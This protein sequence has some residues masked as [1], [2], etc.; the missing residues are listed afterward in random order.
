MKHKKMNVHLK[1]MAD[2][3]LPETADSQENILHEIKQVNKDE[4][5]RSRDGSLGCTMI[6]V[7]RNKTFI[8]NPTDNTPQLTRHFQTHSSSQG[9]ET[10]QSLTLMVNTE[11]LKNFLHSFLAHVST[12]HA[13][14]LRVRGTLLPSILKA[15]A[16]ISYVCMHLVYSLIEGCG[17]FMNNPYR[18]SPV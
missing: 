1:D 17:C 16:Q 9:I 8:R 5:A 11:I 7:S 3:S 18:S 10:L 15:A 4:T 13:S 12:R 6:K 2:K 14:V